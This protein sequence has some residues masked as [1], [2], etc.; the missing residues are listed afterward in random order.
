MKIRTGSRPSVIGRNEF[1]RAAARMSEVAGRV[2]GGGRHVEVTLVGE[3]RMAL[4]NRR[5]KARRGA[6]E[7]LTF[8]YG[9]ERGASPDDP[10]GE[11][12]I[13]WKR[14]E[15]GARR[16]GVPPRAYL[17]RLLAHGLCHLAGHSHGTDGRA[18]RMEAAERRALEG[19]L[20]RR[21][22]DRL[23]PRHMQGR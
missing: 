22:L 23:F 2:H 19:T 11:I 12:L 17:L 5:Y 6:A 21:Q 15:S 20:P 1:E 14:L 4:L 13:C 16:W 8:D 18:R 10:R 9:T 3:R 7:I